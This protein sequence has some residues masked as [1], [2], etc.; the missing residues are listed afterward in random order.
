MELDCLL[1]V[2]AQFSGGMPEVWYSD[3]KAFYAAGTKAAR[4]KQ[5]GGKEPAA[6]ATVRI[7]VARDE[8]FCFYYKDNLEFLE[9]ALSWEA[10]IPSCIQSSWKRMRPCAVR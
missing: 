2:A 7:A 8:A 1:K 10:A 5:T 9:R 4:A 6:G 3:K